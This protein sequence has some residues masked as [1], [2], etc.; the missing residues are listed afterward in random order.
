MFRSSTGFDR[1]HANQRTSFFTI[2]RLVQE[3]HKRLRVSRDD[4]IRIAAKVKDMRIGSRH[5]LSNDKVFI[6]CIKS[7]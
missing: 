1:R 6:E 4:I 3:R 7:Y 5:I 2:A